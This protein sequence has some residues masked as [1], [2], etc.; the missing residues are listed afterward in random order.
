MRKNKGGF[1]IGAA[2]VAGVLSLGVLAAAAHEAVPAVNGGSGVASGTIAAAV[3]GAER[4]QGCGP[5]F[6]NES[7]RFV[8]CF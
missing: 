1:S 2:L 3:E 7:G 6:V 5:N 4:S 8:V